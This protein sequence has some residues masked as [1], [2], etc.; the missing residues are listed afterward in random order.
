MSKLTVILPAYNEEENIETMVLRWQ[1]FR[2]VLNYKYGLELQIIAINDGSKDRT[3]EIA[4]RLEVEHDNFT[5]VSHRKNKG[6]GEAVKTGITYFVGQGDH[7]TYLCL[8]DC[9]NT[10]DPVY[11]TDMLDRID[12]TSSDVVIASRYQKGAEV[13]GVSGMRLL[14]SGGAKYVFSVLLQIPNVKDY[15]CG[16]RLYNRKII[17]SAMER[18]GDELIAESG[19]TCMVELL[20]KLHCCGAV[21]AEVPFA[22]RYDYKKG[23]S[24]MAV[25]KTA[26]NSIWLALRLRK[27]K[28]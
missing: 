25:L 11:I 12:E 3:K 5:L 10:Q 4:E 24:K 9:D 15:T 13:K 7:S 1:Q 17:L 28:R 2:E 6:L 26:V 14:M 19:F 18:F 16:Y 8:M 22:L 21:F 23:D 27:I 20:Y